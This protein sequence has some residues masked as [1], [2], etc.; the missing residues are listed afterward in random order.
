MK[1]K[2][3]IILFFM[4]FNLKAQI[5]PILNHTWT[6][7]K[8]DTGSQVI[9]AD[10]NA[11]GEYDTL[12]LDTSFVSDGFT[13][14]YLLFGHC[15]GYFSFDDSNSS[16]FYHFLG[17][18]IGTE[19]SSQIALY[20]NDIFIQANTNLTVYGNNSIPNVFGPLS[21][22]FTVVGD[23][24]Y[25]DI[26]NTIGE[27]ATF[28]A[29]NLRANEFLEEAFSIF[30]NPVSDKLHI[31]SPEIP[32]EKVR[33]FDLNGKLIKEEK[34]DHNQIKVSHLQKGIYILSIET[35]FGMLRKKLIKK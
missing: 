6:I 12:T 1:T 32:I 33:I 15:E 23:I 5:A 13:L 24:I 14:Y 18:T 4:V 22:S 3:H 25:L 16:L 35:P 21:Y 17:C 10:L 19:F 20:F 8:I 29:N 9:N 7:E 34:L 27:V 26:T 28:S 31:K 30:P 11:F 2:I